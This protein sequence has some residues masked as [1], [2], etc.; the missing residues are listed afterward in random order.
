M[1]F[2]ARTTAS[3]QR[4]HISSDSPSIRGGSDT[5]HAATRTF[6]AR[7]AAVFSARHVVP[8]EPMS[9]AVGSYAKM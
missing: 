2:G 6:V 7:C 9:L 1:V 5:G 4:K 3:H 8:A